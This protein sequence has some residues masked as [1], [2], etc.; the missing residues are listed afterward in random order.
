MML[1]VQQITV[2]CL[3]ACRAVAT[4]FSLE[5]TERLTIGHLFLLQSG[6]DGAPYLKAAELNMFSCIWM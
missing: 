3:V 6:F 2:T 1:L 5:L 4:Q